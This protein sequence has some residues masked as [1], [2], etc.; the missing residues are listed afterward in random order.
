MDLRVPG[1]EE[2]SHNNPNYEFKMKQHN[3]P[4]W[5]RKDDSK[6]L[7]KNLFFCSG[8]HTHTHTAHSTNRTKCTEPSRIRTLLERCKC[9]AAI[10]LHLQRSRLALTWE[11]G[12]ENHPC[13]DINFPA[14]MLEFLTT[15]NW[16]FSGPVH[17]GKHCVLSR[18]NFPC[19]PS[20][21][22]LSLPLSLFPGLRLHTGTAGKATGR[23]EDSVPLP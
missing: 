6:H 15:E 19:V 14:E 11:P 5:G 12:H 20:L 4:F 22:L 13:R 23:L 2:R 21:F 8:I 18:P 9:S 17:S 1:F 10:E 7:H 16:G 3:E